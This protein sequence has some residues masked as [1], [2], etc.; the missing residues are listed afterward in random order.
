[1]GL[2]RYED[3]LITALNIVSKIILICCS[4]LR[5]QRTANT[6]DPKN[7]SLFRQIQRQ[8]DMVPLLKNPNNRAIYP[9][10]NIRASQEGL[11]LCAENIQNARKEEVLL[12]CST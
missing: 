12:L 8:Q 6:L 9:A 2:K 10:M 7:L 5:T 1:M 4:L 11:C 3:S